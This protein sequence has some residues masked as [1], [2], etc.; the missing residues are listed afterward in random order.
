MGRTREYRRAVRKRKIEQR[1]QKIKD[2]RR[3]YDE[4]YENGY[5]H[6]RKIQSA[7][8]GDKGGLFSKGYYGAI[9]SGVKTKTKNACASY[10]HKGG[11]GK[12]VKYSGHDKKQIE[13]MRM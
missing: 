1:K 6:G 9:V 13:R 8:F 2:V 3:F 4:E 5:V 7:V 10:R 11:Y 12:A